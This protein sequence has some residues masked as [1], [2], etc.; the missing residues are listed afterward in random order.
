M[1]FGFLIYYL[2]IGAAISPHWGLLIVLTPALI[3]LM[4]ALGLG[5]GIIVSSLTT[6]YRD[7][8]FLVGFG[9]QLMM[10]GTP[11]IYP[12]SAIP[13]K[14]RWLIQ[15]NPMT[16]PVEAFRALFLGGPIPWSA[17]ATSTAITAALL[18]FGVVI[19]NRVE[20]TFMDTV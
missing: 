4:A 2:A 11:I 8:V 5:A 13:E 14:W 15:L 9:I 6:K 20:K 12:L 7:F 3:L 16:A 18:F 10:Y 17:L 1:F 19:F